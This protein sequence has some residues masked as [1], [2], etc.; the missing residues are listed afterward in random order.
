[1]AEVKQRL[2]G[3]ATI[4]ETSDGYTVTEKIKVAAVG[5]SV[6]ARQ[7]SALI[8]ASVPTIG[9]F[10]PVVPT[11]RV[12]RRSIESLGADYAH[13]IVTWETPSGASVDQVPGDPAI[14]EIDASI[15]MTTT[16]KDTGG[17]TL[18][19]GYTYPA[20]YTKVAGMAG[21]EAES[22]GATADFPQ[23]A[24]SLRVS[25][26]EAR[27]V[28]AVSQDAASHVGTTNST[29]FLGKPPRTWLC[30]RIHGANPID[31]TPTD[32]SYEFTFKPDT[33]DIEVFFVDPYAGQIPA[34][35][36]DGVG[37]RV[38]RVIGESNLNN[39]PISI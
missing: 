24:F 12:I 14:W 37:A 6:I 10:H 34:D 33:W 31:V 1:M 21:Q 19:V 26:S 28:V 35:I 22:Q 4:T 39:L 13:I 9:A 20:N 32:V 16:Q 27:T 2:I 30:T 5:G 29:T 36:V 8:N 15:E 7:Y 23:A 25:Q 11:A 18:A 38:Y 17:A 3:G